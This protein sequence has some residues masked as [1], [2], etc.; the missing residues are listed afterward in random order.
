MSRL[1]PLAFEKLVLNRLHRPKAVG[2][3]K[4]YHPLQIFLGRPNGRQQQDTVL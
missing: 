4:N 2:L 1:T 3:Q